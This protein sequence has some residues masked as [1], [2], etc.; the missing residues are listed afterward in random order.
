M[1][2]KEKNLLGKVKPIIFWH[3]FPACGLLLRKIADEL[4]KNV[5]ICGT[6][7]G[8]PEEI[9][10]LLGHSIIWFDN[11]NDIWERRSEFSDRN[12]IIHSGWTF[13]G[14]R[15]YDRF[16]KKN[17]NA[18]VV[19]MTDNRY[20][21]NL[22]Q[23]IGAIW[24][25]LFLKR[26]F[27]SAF[28]PG[29]EGWKLMKFLGLDASK[30]FTGL[31]GAY[32]GIYKEIVPIEKRKNE[33]LFVGQLIKRKSIDIL[34]KAF[35]EYKRAGGNWNL[36]II[37]DGPLKSICH[38]NG[39]SREGFSQPR[40]IAA[41]MNEAKVLVLVS[42]N[43]NWGT[44]VCEAAACGMHLI[45]SKN[46]GATADIVENGINGIIIK[47]IHENDLRN[48]FFAY[49]NM[50]EDQFRQGSK[51]SKIITNRYNSEAFFKTFLKIADNLI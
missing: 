32:E 9:E 3:G 38:G 29:K 44:V 6:K 51:I 22:R 49:E 31:Y 43:D 46:V 1:T 39:I 45:T 24:F 4:K 10:N 19:V 20:R 41:K 15:K 23:Y 16:M 12:L 28:V 21:G 34:I 5:V 26:P 2:E 25:R 11:P 33:F 42:R 48:A 47:H 30:I 18:K 27:D 50:S 36:K 17:F 37:G 13:K 40:V 7:M 35:C 14:W 8:T